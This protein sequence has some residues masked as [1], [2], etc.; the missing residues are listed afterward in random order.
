MTMHK[1]HHGTMENHHK[2]ME[3]HYHV[4]LEPIVMSEVI[5]TD[6]INNIAI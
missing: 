1:T 6:H 5:I 2:T 3:W 4:T